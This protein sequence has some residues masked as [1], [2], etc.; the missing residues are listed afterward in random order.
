MRVMDID[1]NTKFHPADFTTDRYIGLTVFNRKKAAPVIVMMSKSCN[2]P[3]YMV[4]DGFFKQM[5][6]LN[7]ADAIDYCKRMGYIRSGR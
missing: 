4:S 5:Y 7:Y 2:P 6:Y 3:H 1:S